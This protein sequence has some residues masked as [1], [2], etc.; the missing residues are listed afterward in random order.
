M[1]TQRVIKYVNEIMTKKGCTNW[2][3]DDTDRRY[4]VYTCHCGDKGRHTKQNLKRPQWNGCSKCSKKKV[5]Y[6]VQDKIKKRLKDEGYELVRIESNRKIKYKCEHDTFSTYVSNILR[7]TW[8]GSCSRCA[9]REEIVRLK[10]RAK[11]QDH[12]A[13]FLLSNTRPISYVRGEWYGGSHQGGISETTTGFKVTFKKSQGGHS[14]TFNIS[15]YGREK[16]KYLAKNHRIRES[17]RR[18]ISKN[19][20]RDVRVI[21]H[22]LLPRGYIFK[23]IQLPCGQFMMC[24]SDQIEFLEGLP[25]RAIKYKGKYTFYAYNGKKGIHNILYPELSQVDHIDRNG[26]NNLRCNIRDG[27]GRVNPT[28]RR[29]P[30]NNTSGYKGVTFEKG[31]K[32]RWK[33][34]WVDKDS[35]KRRTKSFSVSKYGDDDA[36]KLAIAWRMK[37]APC[38]KDF[39]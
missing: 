27:S 21:S 4:I 23:E 37:H 32:A 39:V 9:H 2:E 12:K 20:V 10:E 33:A 16:A 26:L 31:A 8:K 7:L 14:T 18:G 17:I 15:K 6:R 24:E 22:P 38:A 19:M 30:K 29:K 11:N 3:I 35:G 5:S 36:K 13:K 1:T 25:L 34:Q 28:N